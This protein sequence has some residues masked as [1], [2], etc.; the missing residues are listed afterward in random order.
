M[1]ACARHF[2]L[3]DKML[4]NQPFLS[5]EALGLADIPAGTHLYRYF[6]LDIDRPSTPNVQ[7]WYA[8][9]RD[10]PAYREHVMIPF[11]EMKGKLAY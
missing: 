8:R 1:A 6:A 7:A 9:L 4:A 2:Q 11:D 3:L 10:R 5:G